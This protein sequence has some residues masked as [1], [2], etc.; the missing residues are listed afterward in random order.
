MDY[1]SD[2]NCGCRIT[3]FCHRNLKFLTLENEL[4]KITLIPDKGADVY[5]LIYKPKDIDFMWK[6]P[7]G[8]RDAIHTK[9]TAP[10]PTG[11]FLDYYEGGWQE[12]LPGGGPYLENGAVIG[13]HG[14]ACMLPWDFC[15]L[16]DEEDF[17]E[18]QLS[19]KTYRY[20][21][22]VKKTV[23]I[24]KGI[25]V[26]YFSECIGNRG[27]ED[28]EIMWGHHPAVGKPFLNEYCRIDVPATDYLML[29]TNFCP[30]NKMQPE[31]TGKW[32]MAQTM[33]GVAVDLTWVPA[34]HAKNGNLIYLSGLKEAW[35][36]VTDTRK[37]LGYGMCWDKEVFPYVWYWQVAQ[38]VAGHPWYSATYNIAMEFWSAYPSG[39]EAARQKTG[40]TNL[41]AQGEMKTRYCFVV[42]EGLDGVAH[43]DSRGNVKQ[44]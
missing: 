18:V 37:K 27:N 19:C 31:L 2:R 22:A 40:L 38:G 14:E 30:G 43:I 34:E 41:S 13:L 29:G 28:L 8:V 32:P 7:G 16:R 44:A 24:K 26:V 11:S 6:A 5:E 25:P 15:V 17:C 42:Y 35:F 12:C 33:D 21:L 4:I 1:R 10:D 39:R 23:Q 3:E 20:P 9:M 36:A